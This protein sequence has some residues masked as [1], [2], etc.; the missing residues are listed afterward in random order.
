M[1]LNQP[2]GTNSTPTSS[3]AEVSESPSAWV[4]GL[5]ISGTIDCMDDNRIN[6]DQNLADF[7]LGPC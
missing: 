2:P 7:S 5:V 1:S 3:A 4:G 6:P